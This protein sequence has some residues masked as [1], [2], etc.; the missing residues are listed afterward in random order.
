MATV[1]PVGLSLSFYSAVADVAVTAV[2][3]LVM[4]TAA[5]SLSSFCFSAAVAETMVSESAEMTDVALAANL[6]RK[7]V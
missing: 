2:L 5:A 6:L 4:E 7:T 1:L 3:D